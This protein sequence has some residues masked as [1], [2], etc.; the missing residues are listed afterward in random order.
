MTIPGNRTY[1]LFM[2]HRVVVYTVFLL[3]FIFP[4]SRQVVAQHC[5]AKLSGYVIDRS[6]GIALSYAEVLLEDE[7]QLAVCDQN[8]FFQFD[9]L[10]PGELHIQVTHVGCHSVH[11]YIRFVHDTTIRILL[12]HHAEFLDEMIVHGER[13]AYNIQ[14]SHTLDEH[15]IGDESQKSLADLIE[16]LPGVSSLKGGSGIAKPVIQGLYGNR[17]A[18]SNNGL[19]HG[20]QLWGNDHAPE[21]DPFTAGHISVVKGAG[22]LEYGGNSLGGIVL[23]EPNPIKDDPNLHGKLNYAFSQ[24]GMGHTL[25]TALEQQAKNIGWRGTLTLKQSGDTK[26]PEYYLTNTGRSEM[27]ASL[28]I[29]PKWGANWNHELYYSFVNSNIGILRGSHIGNLTD[30]EAAFAVEVPYFTRETFSYNI[31]EPRQEVGH[32]L[33]KFESSFS[34]NPDRLYRLK[35]GAQ[36]NTRKEFDVR[37]AGRSSDPAL[38]LQQISQFGE[39]AHIRHFSDIWTLK[40]GIQFSSRDN[41][42]VPGTGV[43]PLIPNYLLLSPGTFGI[44]QRKSSNNLFEL[45]VRYDYRY[46]SVWKLNPEPPRSFQ[47]VQKNFHPV[48]ISSGFRMSLKDSMSVLL[49]T[50]YHIR[51]PEVNELYSFGLH[52]GVSGIEEGNEN[53]NS[54]KSLK[55]SITWDWIEKQRWIIQYGIFA[56]SIRDFMYLNPSGEYRLTIRGAFPLFQYE[57]THAALFGNDLQLSFV[58]GNH[59]KFATSLSMIRGYDLSGQIPLLYIPADNARATIQ[60]SPKDGKHLQNRTIVVTGK[61]VAKQNRLETDQDFLPAP[62]AYALIEL[63]IGAYIPLKKGG[64]DMHFVVENATN[65]SYRDYLNRLRYFADETGRNIL[66][67]VNYHFE[68]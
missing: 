23:I 49:N 32:H 59:W 20:G 8:G 33:L 26:T 34:K 68:D 42:N 40:S 37:R 38:S 4:L 9:R 58:P 6:T 27:A 22:A 10:C 35:Y 19:L 46:L 16:S 41:Y 3:L 13:G 39:L 51:A 25:N 60:F 50:S 66:I 55:A 61:G 53:L 54:E 1:Y 47:Q 21:I 28:L 12:S 48:A 45:G 64:F 57:Q 14:H 7:K 52:Q 18:I 30:L 67:R 24:N 5:E 29:E 43:L 44:V 63:N 31:A 56:Q 65:K 36:I 11:L 2:F 15:R 62:D 17:I